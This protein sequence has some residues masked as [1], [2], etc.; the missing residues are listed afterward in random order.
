[1]RTGRRVALAAGLSI[2][3]AT[4]AYGAPGKGCV[5]GRLRGG[6]GGGAA[7]PRRAARWWSSGVAREVADYAETLVRREAVV[8]ADATGA[9]RYEIGRAVAPQSVWVAVDLATGGTAAAAPAGFELVESDFR[10]RGVLRGLLSDA[11]GLEDAR[12]FLEVLLVR[13]GAVGGAWGASVGDGGAA[14]EDGA[15]DGKLRVSLARLRPVGSS[16]AA[17]ERF[18]P[19]DTVAAI[20]PRSLQLTLVTLQGGRP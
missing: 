8:T 13:P 3:L 11:D 15:G 12:P 1:M 9:A 19:G 16:G 4:A 6:G 17:P 20:E 2:G 7:G 14:D 10:G 5:G 18:A